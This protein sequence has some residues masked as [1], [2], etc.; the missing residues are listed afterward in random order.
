[1][2]MPAYET[3]LL[4]TLDSLTLINTGEELILWVSK[5]LQLTF[6]HGAFICG[7]GQVHSTSVAPFKYFTSNFPMDYLRSL[8]KPNGLYFS[9]AI[10][11]WLETN[12]VQLLD[13]EYTDD[14]SLDPEWLQHFRRSG[15][16]NIAAYGIYDSYRQYASYFSFHQ[17]PGPLGEQQRRLLKIFVPSMHATLLR[18]LNNL[19]SDESKAGRGGKLSP[20]EIE[21]L[22]WVSA[23]KTSYEIATIL[24]ISC[25][26]VR[27]HIQKILVK[28]RVSTRS[29]AVVRAI[30]S[31]LLIPP[32][33]NITLPIWTP[34]KS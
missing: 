33:T 20:R 9:S 8:T 7:M 2:T 23:G 14:V 15:L 22:N 29:Q 12:D 26:T 34:P 17:I 32:S 10:K 1:M 27:N 4:K 28:L 30:N 13:V 18:I 5:D 31:G 11:L 6:P 21:I 24:G 25:S 16:R 3:Q 19:K